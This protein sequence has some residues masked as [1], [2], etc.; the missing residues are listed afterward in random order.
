MR[1]LISCR[2]EV[3]VRGVLQPPL[4][5]ACYVNNLEAVKILCQNGADTHLENNYGTRP[6]TSAVIGASRRGWDALS[7]LLAHQAG[8]PDLSDFPMI[9]GAVIGTSGQAILRCRAVF[10]YVF[11]SCV[12]FAMACTGLFCVELLVNELPPKGWD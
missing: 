11:F 2:A 7:E 4:H 3:D 6:V 8:Q 10:A 12:F 1:F 9:A 5:T